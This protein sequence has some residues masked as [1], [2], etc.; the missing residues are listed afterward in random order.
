ME[1]QEI[2]IDGITY[3]PAKSCSCNDCVFTIPKCQILE[4]R[5]CDIAL[6][7]LFDGHVL[8]VKED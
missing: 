4:K 7:S 5:H 3:I 1:I 8:K 2:K 6:C